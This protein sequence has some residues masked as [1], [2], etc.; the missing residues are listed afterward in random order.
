MSIVGAFFLLVITCHAGERS[1]RGETSR[2]RTERGTSLEL[3]FLQ[4]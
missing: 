1:S 4:K 3:W 2:Y